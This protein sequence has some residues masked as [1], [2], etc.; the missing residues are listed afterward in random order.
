MK[1][2]AK[3]PCAT[4]F[5][6]LS[7]LFLLSACSS[8]SDWSEKVNPTVLSY[9]GLK[10]VIVNGTITI[11]GYTGQSS[12][13]VIPQTIGGKTVTA[14][15]EGAFAGDTKLVSISIPAT[16]TS[17]GSSA[18]SGCTA[19]VS[20]TFG[21][22]TP[23]S[24][25]TDVF[26]DCSALTKIYVPSSAYSLYST[27]SALAALASL[28]TTS[29]SAD[30]SLTSL[31]IDAGTLTPA[32]DASTTEYTVSVGESV[33]SIDL[34]PTKTD[35]NA[36]VTVSPAQ[37]MALSTG[38]NTATITVTSLDG[39]VRTY[40]VTITVSAPA[41]G[42]AGLSVTDSLDVALS[43]SSSYY[44][45]STLS[46]GYDMKVSA[47]VTDAGSAA[48]VSPD[49]YAWYLDG[50]V[51]TSQTASSITLGATLAKGAHS[52][53]CVA[54]KGGLPASSILYFVIK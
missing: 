9:G 10:Y 45:G 13:L 43:V 22:T 41:P 52:I 44:S 5:F 35:E 4:I 30:A 7:I 39:T 18:F 47:A 15:A 20:V 14:I 8:Y 40:T 37:P 33:D 38:V 48:S 17:I 28:F 21:A 19:L 51:Q 42:S 54:K 36:T 29:T 53:A 23:P 27:S 50:T 25:G 16:V 31:T 34:T 6:A 1:Q 3:R 12:A 49:S 24:L 46:Y 32:F 11:V 26:K 2:S